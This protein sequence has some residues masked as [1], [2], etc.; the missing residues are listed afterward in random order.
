MSRP[1]SVPVPAPVLTSR[2]HATIRGMGMGMR[3]HLNANATTNRTLP[4]RH[5]PLQGAPSSPRSRA[6]CQFWTWSKKRGDAALKNTRGRSRW[7]VSPESHIQPLESRF[8]TKTVIALLAVGGLLF[9]ALGS[10]VLVEQLTFWEELQA[11]GVYT[12]QMSREQN[13]EVLE[14]HFQSMGPALLREYF[15]TLPL[16]APDMRLITKAH[17]QMDDEFAKISGVPMT[18][19]VQLEANGVIVSLC[20]SGTP[21]ASA[22]RCQHR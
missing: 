16:G 21:S 18:H 6:I 8:P 15:R 20:P 3:T 11:D 4:L 17:W 14:S 12:P 1:A 9:W 13:E 10:V 7:T 19:A 2:G 5:Q 22:G